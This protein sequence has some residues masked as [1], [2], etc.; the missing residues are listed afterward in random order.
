M[1]SRS[2]R[3]EPI[4][5]QI[6]NVDGS[7]LGKS[8]SARSHRSIPGIVESNLDS[9]I[10]TL[11]KDEP[12]VISEDRIPGLS[13]IGVVPQASM[14]QTEINN[15]V[16]KEVNVEEAIEASGVKILHKQGCSE[17]HQRNIEQAGSDAYCSGMGNVENSIVYTGA[18]QLNM[19]RAGVLPGSELV[20]QI[21]NP[22]GCNSYRSPV[23]VVYAKNPEAESGVDSG[24]KSN[25]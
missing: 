25:F 19:F 1:R 21:S 24:A 23:H 18:N 22:E 5:E 6:L 2:L 14:A 15:I 20:R 16:H 4:L 13:G 9:A 17:V 3:T 8:D 7:Y 11:G 10:V 12:V